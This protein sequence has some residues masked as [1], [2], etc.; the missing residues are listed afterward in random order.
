MTRKAQLKEFLQSISFRELTLTIDL[1]VSVYIS[2][3]YIISLINATAEQLAS[4]S[5][6]SGLLLEVLTYSVILMVSSY[7]LLAFISDDELKQPLD[8]REKQINLVGYKSKAHILQAGICVAIFQYQAEANGWGPAIEYN[9]PYLPMHV[10]VGAFLLAEIANYA[11][12]LYKGRTGQIY[13]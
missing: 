9:I 11:A 5:W 10:M 7:L 6:L 12:Q 13:E 4:V 3:I 2:Y 1:L 8:V